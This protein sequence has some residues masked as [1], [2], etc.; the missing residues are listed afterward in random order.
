MSRPVAPVPT[1]APPGKPGGLGEKVEWTVERFFAWLYDNLVSPISD[2]VRN[3]VDNFLEE[4]ESHLTP[5]SAGVLDELI[6]SPDL[7]ESIKRPLRQARHPESP[8]TVVAV[9]TAIAG[10]LMGTVLGFL[11]PFGRIAEYL[12]ERIAHTARCDPPTAISI[13]RRGLLA[14]TW[15]RDQLRDQGWKDEQVNALIEVLRP[16]LAPGDL[17]AVAHRTGRPTA[18][19]RYEMQKRGYTPEDIDATEDLSKFRPGPAD[20]VRMGVRE[21]WRD[22]VAAR[23][24]YDADFP[25]EFAAEMERWGDEGGAWAHRYWRAHWDLPGLTTVLDMLYRTDFS[26]DDLET[27]LRISDIP[28]AWR[29]YISQ[30]AYRPLTRVDVRRM[31]GLGVLSRADVKRN[32]LDLGYD[33]VNAERMTE[34]TVKYETDEDRKASKSDILSG[35]ELGMLSPDEA[36]D[37]LMVIGYSR[38]L[39]AYYVQREQAKLAREEIDDQVKYI[40]ELYVHREIT[41]PE[42]SSRLTGLGLASGEIE[43]NLTTWT[44]ARESGTERP[45]RATL[46]KFFKRDVITETEYVSGLRVLGYQEQYVEQYLASIL[47]EKAE[48]ARKEEERARREQEDIRKRKV[49]SDYQVAKAELDVDIAEV[50]TAVAETQSALQERTLRY[51]NDLRLAREALSE[52]ELEE[53]AAKDIDDLQAGIAE[54]REAIGFLDTQ[55]ESLE[56]QAADVKLAA[57]PEVATVSPE[58]ADRLLKEIASAIERL[59]DDVATANLEITKLREQVRLRRVRLVEELEI[60]ARIRTTE[61]IESVFAADQ[62]EMLHRLVDLRANLAGLK[63]DKAHLAV[64]YRAG[65]AE[66]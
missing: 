40:K 18:A 23:W 49:K 29:S 56:T 13:T 24:G 15:A 45:S 4:A 20:L 52:A 37:W 34:F 21:A 48:D 60:V 58:D 33:D 8:V 35:L 54:Y 38:D 32:Y 19:A 11:R 63:E 28:A 59:Q 12:G 10:I 26:L 62:A 3:G 50:T 53:R 43:R 16:R 1:P 25:A 46:D 44:I 65:L 42:A 2:R 17:F 7:P 36:T 14:E 5:A 57:L 55:I 51:R 64:G 61:E 47:S 22:D 39:A 41:A 6:A 27:Y 30:I 9:L 66:E 31:Y